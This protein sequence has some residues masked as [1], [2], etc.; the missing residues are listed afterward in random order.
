MAFV[1]YPKHMYHAKHPVKT[2]MSEDEE[3]QLGSEWQTKPVEKSED[4]PAEQPKHL[5]AVAS[6]LIKS[7]DERP[8][9]VLTPAGEPLDHA[10]DASETPI[11]IK[12]RKK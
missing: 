7:Q 3:K 11:V 5:P 10:E 8:E 12:N 2:V 9:D 1:E 4:A 6:V